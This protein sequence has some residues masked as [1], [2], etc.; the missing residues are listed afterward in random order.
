MEDNK[1]IDNIYKDK[2]IIYDIYNEDKIYIKEKTL[3][4]GAEGVAYLVSKKDTN[5]EYVAKIIEE[6]KKKDKK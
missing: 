5:L 4:R 1:I 2:K 6:E 3:G